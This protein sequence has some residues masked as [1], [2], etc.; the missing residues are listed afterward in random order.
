MADRVTGSATGGEPRISALPVRQGCLAGPSRPLDRRINAIRD[1][2]ADAALVGLVTAPR[3][4]DG[5]FRRCAVTAAML[6]ARADDDAVA[7]SELLFGEAFIVFDTVPGWAWGQC[8][9]DRY[10]G[11][12]RLAA[13][14]PIGTLAATHWVS[15]PAAPVFATADLKA[16]VVATLP[17][18][19]RFP[20]GDTIGS[21]VAAAGG[22]VH[23]R[24]VR[25]LSASLTDPAAVALDFVGTPYVWGGRTRG[26]IDC[27]GLTQAALRACGVFCPRDSDQQ[28]AAF[29]V[30]HPAERQRGDLVTF[31]GHVGIL[32]DADT[33]VHANAN[34]MTTLAE[35]LAGVAA[36]LAPTAFHRPPHVAATPC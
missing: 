24:H 1:D 18:H 23:V 29:A 28:A 31:P 35:P 15:A 13:L 10:V 33:L 21:F 27:S 6:R 16:R 34:S 26:G 20:A 12:V 5:V 3:Y 7:V 4:A 8:L 2:L 32:A 9:Y 30:I 11:W 17:M 36:R 19:A 25:P 22:F 14:A